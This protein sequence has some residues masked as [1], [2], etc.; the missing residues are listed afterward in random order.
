MLLNFPLDGHGPLGVV[1][2]LAVL[3]KLHDNADE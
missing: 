1:D 3:E 2:E